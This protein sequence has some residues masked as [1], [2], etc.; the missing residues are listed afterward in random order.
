MCITVKY[1]SHYLLS[2]KTAMN[3]AMSAK[4]IDTILQ[5]RVLCEFSA[6]FAFKIT[7]GTIPLYLSCKEI[8]KIMTTLNAPI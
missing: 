3:I 4:D 6:N 2:A 8:I 5:L 1:K 7:C